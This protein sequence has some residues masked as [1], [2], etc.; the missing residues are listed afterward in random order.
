MTHYNV[1]HAF[2]NPI[3]IEHATAELDRFR[4]EL[5]YIE[6]DMRSAMASVYDRYTAD[7]WVRSFLE[8]TAAKLQKWY[9]AREKLLSKEEWPRRPLD[10]T[11]D[12][13]N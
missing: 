3:Y 4:A 9:D 1:I 2:S 12:K 6:R 11:S 13:D 10:I 7:E 5:G 8:P